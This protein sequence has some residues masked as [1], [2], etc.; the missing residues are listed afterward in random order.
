MQDSK[1]D[2]DDRQMVVAIRSGIRLSTKL[3]ANLWFA[4][5]INHE[6]MDKER[7]DY[8][9]LSGATAW[10]GS[11][12]IFRS[13]RRRGSIHQPKR[14]RPHVGQGAAVGW[15]ALMQMFHEDGSLVAIDSTSILVEGRWNV[16]VLVNRG[17]QLP[18]TCVFLGDLRPSSLSWRE[19]ASHWSILL[20]RLM[21]ESKKALAP[22][23]TSDE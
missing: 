3:A 21:G 20:R 15:G 18:S 4:L 7:S 16:L 14:S 10:L 13:S 1:I 22:G 11:G 23:R 12:L 17:E 19:T 2:L 5:S 9:S 6:F 8:P